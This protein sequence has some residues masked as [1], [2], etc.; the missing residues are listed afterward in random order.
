MI[1]THIRGGFQQIFEFLTDLKKPCVN[2]DQLQFWVSLHM[3]LHQCIH[4]LQLDYYS[5][6]EKKIQNF[7]ESIK[8][9][10]LTV[11]RIHISLIWIQFRE[12][13]LLKHESLSGSGFSSVFNCSQLPLYFLE[14][15][16]LIIQEL[17]I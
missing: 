14:N 11:F 1:N 3:L 2:V 13:V 15:Y 12:S 16:H 5:F 4:R 6:L 10:L 7:M 17:R 9:S 8:K